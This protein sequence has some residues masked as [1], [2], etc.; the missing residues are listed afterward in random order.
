MGK[1]F[2]P[3]SPE[4]LA[5]SYVGTLIRTCNS[6]YL[7]LKP[8]EVAEVNKLFR[9]AANM[10]KMVQKILEFWRAYPTRYTDG[11]MDWLVDTYNDVRSENDKKMP[12][13]SNKKVWG[14]LR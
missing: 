9:N 3:P 8:A 13:R 12:D 6:P 1:P 11:W 4:R 2:D 10:K 5:I 7:H 14:D